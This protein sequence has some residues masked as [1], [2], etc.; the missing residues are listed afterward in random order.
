M[1]PNLIKILYCFIVIKT[2]RT[3]TNNTKPLCLLSNHDKKFKTELDFIV[4]SRRQ[5]EHKPCK[6]EDKTQP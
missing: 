2:I 4:C 1:L 3:T 6:E 5:Q